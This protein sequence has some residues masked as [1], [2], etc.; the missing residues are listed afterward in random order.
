MPMIATRVFNDNLA[1]YQRKRRRALNEGGTSSS[2]T[3]SILQLLT[4][5]SR[6]S[7]VPL[8][9]S[10]VS[11]TLPHLKKGAVR[12]F[13][14]I[15]EETPDNNSRFNKTEQTYTFS[16]K[17]II[18]FFGADEEAKVRG[19]RRHILFLNEANNIPWDTARGLDIRTQLFTFCD[20]NPVAEFWAHENWLIKDETGAFIGSNGNVYIHSTY[21]DVKEVLPAEIVAN[22]ESN[23]DKDPNWWRIYGLGLLGK[24]EGLVYP[25]FEQVSC[26]P[27]GE[28]FYG[29]DYGFAT[30]PTVLVKNVVIGESLYS[31][32]LFYSRAALTN[33]QIGREMLQAG[34][35]P[36]EPIYPDPNEPKSAQELR[37]QGFMVP[38]TIKG[39]GSVGFG[40]KQVNK[41][42]QHWTQG[43]VNCIKEQRNFRYIKDKQTERFTDR[44]GHVWS[45]GMDARR[46]AVASHNV[47]SLGLMSAYQF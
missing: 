24:I 36:N 35:L 33:D 27:E 46:Y 13:F 25:H 2:K 47:V 5:I 20:W 15:L 17:S 22:I 7:K 26:L 21:D 12:D 43:S 16:S 32:E 18:E 23:R 37:D 38:D 34:V 40:I 45:H 19:P 3:W 31:E 41:Y 29:L 39:K 14:N 8:I 6:H 9:T 11:E 10:V 1:A 44:T 4:L 42:Y 30:D 28:V